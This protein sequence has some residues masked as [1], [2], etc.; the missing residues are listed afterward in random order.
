M[1]RVARIAALA[2]VA[3]VLVLLWPVVR[4]VKTIPERMLGFP[5]FVEAA[6]DGQLTRVMIRG[7]VLSGLSKDGSVTLVTVSPPH[8]TA[9]Y[10]AFRESGVNYY[11]EPEGYPWGVFLLGAVTGAIVLGLLI[12]R[13][14]IPSRR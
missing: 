2:I 1:A 3:V 8:Y 9:H 13:S 10:D 4:S 6:Q 11:V 5:E 7:H 12:I 14:F